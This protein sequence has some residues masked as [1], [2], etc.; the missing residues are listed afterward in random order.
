MKVASG[1]AANPQYHCGHPTPADLR[2]GSSNDCG[3]GGRHDRPFPAY[4]ASA[5]DFWLVVAPLVLP[6]LGV[7]WLVLLALLIGFGIVT[8]FVPPLILSFLG[9]QWLVARLQPGRSLNPLVALIAGLVVFVVLTA[10]P[11]VG[12]FFH[13]IVVFLGLGALWLGWRSGDW[14]GTTSESLLAAV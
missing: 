7:G 4:S 9:G 2:L 5:G 1:L 13:A 12:G 10:L 6:V 11:V 3:S 14:G 8:N